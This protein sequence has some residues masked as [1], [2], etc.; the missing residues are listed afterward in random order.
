MDKSWFPIAR[1]ANPECNR[2]ILYSNN[3]KDKNNV[4]IRIAESRDG[5]AILC[6]K[7]KTMLQIIHKPIVST[8]CIAIPI[9]DTNTK[10]KKDSEPSSWL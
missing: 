10:S 1:C 6:P 7:C 5:I 4:I 9:L 2:A 3:P 8:G